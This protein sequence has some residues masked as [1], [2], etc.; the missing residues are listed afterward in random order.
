M[1]SEKKT[2]TAAEVRAKHKEF[3]FPSTANYYEEPRRARER[4]GLPR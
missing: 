3:L 1:S 2:P 4:Q